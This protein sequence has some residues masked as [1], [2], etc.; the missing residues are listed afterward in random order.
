V[1]NI[2]GPEDTNLQPP[3]HGGPHKPFGHPLRLVVASFHPVYPPIDIAVLK[4][5]NIV[6]AR[7]DTVGGD[8]LDWFRL[9]VASES[10]HGQR[11]V[12]CVGL[13]RWVGVDIVDRCGTVED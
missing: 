7:K 12:D 13:N 1:A 2:S 4:I 11:P 10:N 6:P 8:V 3:G 9:G 5:G